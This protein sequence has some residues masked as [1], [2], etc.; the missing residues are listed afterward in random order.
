MFNGSISQFKLYD[1][2]LTTDEVKT[3][4]DMGRCD[5]GHHVVNFSKTRVGIGLGD[6][7]APQAALD[8]RG[9]AKFTGVSNFHIGKLVGNNGGILSALEV[10]GY[11][12]ANWTPFFTAVTV[13]M[14]NSY[15]KYVRL[16]SLFYVTFDM[17][18]SGLNTSDASGVH[19]SGLP[20]AQL[21]SGNYNE[22]PALVS[23]H[24]DKTTMFSLVAGGGRYGA[25]TL[26]LTRADSG[27]NGYIAYNSCVSTGRLVGCALLMIV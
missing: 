2:A 23:I 6:G 22:E 14:G 3:L 21:N 17:S 27:G 11:E 10:G 8:V 18:Y 26:L 20:F 5:E 25:S 12:E 4:Y 15:G 24:T 13:T 19:I 9:E 16:G 7:E 1:T